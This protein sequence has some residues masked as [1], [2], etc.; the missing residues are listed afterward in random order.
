MTN[1]ACGIAIRAGWNSWETLRR[2]AKF[3]E[4]R[5]FHSLWM[6]EDIFREEALASLGALAVATNK[7]RLGVGVLNPFTRAPQLLGMAAVTLSRL[8][9]GRFILGL[10]RGDDVIIQKRLGLPF[11][12]SFTLLREC[13][14]VAKDLQNEKLNKQRRIGRISQ[15]V[16][17]D[18]LGVGHVPV[19]IG[20]G[21]TNGAI[22]AG[23]YSDGLIL[24]V[25]SS[26][27]YA[28]YVRDQFL[29]AAKAKGRRTADLTMAAFLPVFLSHSDNTTN[30]ATIKRSIAAWLGRFSYGEMLLERS[31][32]DKTI[33]RRITHNIKRGRSDLAVEFI[34]NE[35][36]RLLCA[37]GPRHD[38]ERR[39]E[40][41]RVA[42]VNT[43][44]LVPRL[45]SFRAIART[46]S[47][48]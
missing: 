26:I 31:G 45:Q 9:G 47:T 23:K 43:V 48:K 2:L 28:A 44:V 40:D 39:I 41:L 27:S 33:F 20:T 10:G 17:T 30:Y 37:V 38:I 12:K 34:S 16:D 4:S 24:N 14:M 11:K 42:G 32:V 36:V 1:F 15:V 13:L 8:S 29:T 35:I 21:G 18:D 22:F 3:S 5:G 7:I 6:T 46:L 25:Y 19:W